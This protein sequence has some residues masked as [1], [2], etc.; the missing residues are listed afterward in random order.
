MDPP[1]ARPRD[2]A[3]SG[4]WLCGPTTQHD[5]EERDKTATR[6]TFFVEKGEDLW[7]SSLCVGPGCAQLGPRVLVVRPS[8]LPAS[9]HIGTAREE[10]ADAMRELRGSAGQMRETRS[11][12]ARA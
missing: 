3:F 6:L 4:Y 5:H 10:G 8:E 1:K 2:A 9:V 7:P 11:A 12:G